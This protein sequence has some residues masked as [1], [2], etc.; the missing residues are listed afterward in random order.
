MPDAYV[1]G[2]RLRLTASRLIG[3]GGE[4]EIYD[5]GGGRVLKLFK[6]P[7]HPDYQGLVSEQEGARRRIETH[8]EKLRD[9]PKGL[10]ARVIAPIELATNA[11]G[12]RVLGYTMPFFSGAEVLMRYRERRFREQGGI[13]NQTVG[14]I[15][16]DLHTT[17][18]ETHKKGVVFG[19]F[20]DLNVLVKGTEAHVVDI[21]SCQFGRYLTYVFTAQFVDPTLCD[22]KTN[23]M[24]LV[25]PHNE[26]SDWYAFAV[27]YM[28]S[29]LYV[30]P[31]GGVYRPANQARRVNH[32]ERPLHRITV[33]NPEVRY[34]K[35]AVPFSVLP[36]AL[37]EYFHRL[38]EKDERGVFPEN[39]L[40]LS[41]VKCPVCGT[42]HARNKCPNCAFTIQIERQEV[43]T[44]RGQVTV[45]KVFSTTGII[46]FA[47]YQGSKLLYL[48]HENGQYKREDGRAVFE[49]PLDPSTRFRVQGRNTLIGRQGRVRVFKPDMTFDEVLVDG[50][51][52]LPVF[53]ANDANMFWT[54]NDSLVKNGRYAPEKIGAILSGQT[55]FWV[56]PAF[57]FGFYRAGNISMAFVFDTQSHALNDNVKLPTIRG[58]L[59]DSTA[60][61]TRDL[62][63]FFTSTREGAKTVN[64]C[65]QIRRDGT[66]AG[67]AEADAD[68]GSWLGTIRGKAAAGNLLFAPTDEGIVRVESQN[69]QISVTREFPDTEP[70]VDATAQLF[71]GTNGIYA[72]TRKEVNLIRIG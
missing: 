42:E 38:F 35:A 21:D 36:D 56:G 10:P 5:I 28:W 64:R 46:V 53:D 1:G 62:C 33:F 6:L 49:E 45:V 70:F 8:Q 30:D 60:V 18:V 12:D 65:Y 61:F 66:V 32:D 67:T 19:D 52:N 15:F 48:Y 2:Q 59:V 47:A 31:Y 9:F 40:T 51:G 55:L 3:Q 58:Q 13:T 20:N 63:W 50:F 23:N 14:E 16:T 25:R 57:G 39:L 69:G 27:M 17:V 26:M 24:Q 11:A 68:D 7:S 44:V 37:L 29:L 22:P 43:K 4:A 34:P 41:W 72:V 54:T 71:I